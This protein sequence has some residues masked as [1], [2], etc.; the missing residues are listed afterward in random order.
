MTIPLARRLD[1]SEIPVID[2]S[3]TSVIEEIHRACTEIGFFY[4]VLPVH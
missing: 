4:V 2:I 3:A 1:F